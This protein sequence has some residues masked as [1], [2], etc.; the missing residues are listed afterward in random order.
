M[1]P[2]ETLFFNAIALMHVNKKG[3][4]MLNDMSEVLKNG[5]EVQSVRDLLDMTG[6]EFLRTNANEVM[7][8]GQAGFGKEFVEEVVLSAEL[9][10]RLRESGSI[11]AKATIKQMGGKKV[12][13]AVRGAK[14]R[15]VGTTEN[16]NAPT[17]GAVAGENKKGRT[18]SIS[19]EAKTLIVTVY[20]SDE[21]LEDSLFDIA[22]FVMGE[23]TDAYETSLHEIIINGD[24]VTGT[25][26][27]NWN[28][29]NTSTL[30]DG[31]KTDFIKFDGGRKLAITKS[32][33]VN[34][35]SNLAVVNIRAARALM[36][37]KGLNPANLVM[38]PDTET[39]FDLMNLS[40]VETL[41]KFGDA[42]TIKNGVLTAIDGIEIVNREEMLKAAATGIIDGVTPGNNSKGQILIVHAPSL[43]V[44]IRRGLTTETSRYA[45]EQETGITGSARVAVSWNDV[46]NN[47][48]AT[49]PVALIINI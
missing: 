38:I 16:S 28:G 4:D 49:S 8:T 17:G 33:T 7:S 9:I 46:Q 14:I 15:M 10:D 6:A 39:Y 26:N 35:G 22:E 11:L 31:N 48:S 18:A 43:V 13:T 2:K 1:T 36:G 37:V 24:T 32:A 44:G 41:E 23:I 29:A 5:G 40:P 21:L 30:P 3:G 27:I 20:Y 45:E 42:A 34:A 19:L 12:D 47:K 25:T